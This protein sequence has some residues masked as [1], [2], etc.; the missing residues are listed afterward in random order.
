M[1][2][3]KIWALFGVCVMPAL[4]FGQAVPATKAVARSG[5]VKSSAPGKR[6]VAKAHAGAAPVDEEVGVEL[7]PEDMEVARRVY[8]G[9]FPCELGASVAVARH[10]SRPGFFIVRIRNDTFS[11]RPV[12]SRTGAVRLE[13]GR[14]GALWLQLGNKSMLMSQK[15]GQRLADEC[16]SPEQ[17]VVAEALKR[18]P[19]PSIL[20]A[21]SEAVAK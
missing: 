18:N 11:M 7:T 2:L 21:A 13:D 12:A 5:P 16:V 8:V 1:T 4:V 3:G 10:D 14:A 15:L 19:A 6:S 20:E 17:A 9:L